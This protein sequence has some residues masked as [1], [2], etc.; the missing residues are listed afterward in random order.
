VGVDTSLAM[1][2]QARA[3]ASKT[4]VDL[5]LRHADMRDLRVEEQAD[6]IYCPFRAL[7][8]L[9]TW[10][11]RRRTFERVARSLSNTTA[12]STCSLPVA[13]VCDPRHQLSPQ[14][15][16]PRRLSRARSL[17]VPHCYEREL[18][19]ICAISTKLTVGLTP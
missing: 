15:Q 8:H 12:A 4:V 2:E 6:L 1:L 17:Y 14:R 18:S 10:A 19:T 3:L 13:L 7:L 11:D 5:D 9:P 16:G